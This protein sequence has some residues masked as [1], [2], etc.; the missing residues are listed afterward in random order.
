VIDLPQLEELADQKER[1]EGKIERLRWC[2]N[3]LL[4]DGFDRGELEQLRREVTAFSWRCRNRNE[5]AGVC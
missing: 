1:L 2:L 5:D 3:L 4:L